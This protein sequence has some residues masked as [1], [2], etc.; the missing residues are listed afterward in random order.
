MS[1]LANECQMPVMLLLPSLFTLVMSFQFF[2]YK[3]SK[4][5]SFKI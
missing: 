5:C 1:E 4:F 2:A 3:T